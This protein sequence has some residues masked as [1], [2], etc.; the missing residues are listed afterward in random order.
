MRAGAIALV[1]CA[2]LVVTAPPAFAEGPTNDR[3]RDAVEISSLPF[4]FEQDTAGASR[5]GPRFCSNTA[6]V[7][8][9]YRA[10]E[11]SRVQVDTYGSEYD[12]MLGVYTRSRGVRE[13][14]CNDDRVG[15][16]SAVRFRARAGTTYLIMVGAYGRGPGG[17]LRLHAA[18][19]SS[20]PLTATL[21]VDV[22]GTFDPV[23][24]GAIVG[25][26]TMCSSP[27]GVYLYGVLRQVRDGLYVA[28]GSDEVM[29]YCSA[30]GPSVWTFELDTHTGYA[31]G[32]GRARFTYWAYA[33]DGFRE[34]VQIAEREKVGVT[35]VEG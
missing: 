11:T 3:P 35:L 31:F 20:E 4:S 6:S 16:D 7:F 8:F 25:G 10:A 18:E 22:D 17:W 23:G 15:L 24:G 33:T 28:R 21:E 1:T 30:Y 34:G 9:R 5:T 13:L 2:A 12:T 26:T 32:P 27:V 29:V 14:R 19:V